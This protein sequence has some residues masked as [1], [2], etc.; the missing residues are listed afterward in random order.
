MDARSART[1]RILIGIGLAVGYAFGIGRAILL[2]GGT[3]LLFT[4]VGGGVII[5]L[6][7][8][9]VTWHISRR[10]T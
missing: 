2:G 4:A 8:L 3:P 10:T 1:S 6:I 7:F 5:V 9:V